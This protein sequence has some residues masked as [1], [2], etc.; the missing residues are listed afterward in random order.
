MQKE[1]LLNIIKTV[2]EDVKAK[3]V[4]ILDVQ[5]ISSITDTIVIATGTSSRQVIAI[6]ERIIEKVK[7]QGGKALGIEGRETGEWVLV[8]LG[9]VVVHSMLPQTRDFYQLEKLWHNSNDDPM[10]EKLHRT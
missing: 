9:D 3:D 1:Q 6:A 7:A 10:R 4:K 8:D 2:L 5:E